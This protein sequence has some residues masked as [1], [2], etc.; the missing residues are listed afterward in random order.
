MD[1]L[2]METSIAVTAWTDDLARCGRSAGYIYNMRLY[3]TRMA[4]ACHWATLGSIRSDSLVKWLADLQ[5]GRAVLPSRGKAH[6]EKTLSA[7][8]LNQYLETARCFIRWCR[9][10][11][12]LPWMPSDP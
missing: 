12:P 3:M 10:Q 2:G 11:R 1:H 7:A 4:E 6:H 9:A 5:A 8:T